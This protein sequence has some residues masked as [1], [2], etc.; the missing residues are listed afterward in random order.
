MIFSTFSSNDYTAALVARNFVIGGPW[1]TDRQLKGTD[2]SQIQYL[3][4]NVSSLVRLENADCIRAFANMMVSDYKNVLLVSN[5]PDYN[6]SLWETF[7][8]KAGN[9]VSTYAWMCASGACKTENDY[10]VQ[11]TNWTLQYPPLS[12]RQNPAGIN[13]SITVDHCLA[14]PFAPLC[15]ISLSRTLLLTVILCNVVKVVGFLTALFYQGYQ[16][17]IVLGDAV[18]SL[19]EFPDGNTSNQ[20]PL[21]A[22]DV[23]NGSWSSAFDVTCPSRIP[24]SRIWTAKGQSWFL[25]ASPR[26]WVL[27]SLWYVKPIIGAKQRPVY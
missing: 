1:N 17:L 4:S 2:V 24:S 9:D 3:Q 12:W 27:T 14:E 7:S 25:A 6:N 20:G 19:L 26:R 15:T 18:A 10:V 21:S 23:R 8:F 11:A 5:A 22:N 13:A 16:P